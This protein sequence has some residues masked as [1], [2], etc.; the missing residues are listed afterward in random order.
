MDALISLKGIGIP[1]GST[2]LQFAFPDRY[3]ILDWRALEALGQ[4]KR[5][6]Y[7]ISFWVTYVDACRKIAQEAGVS[8]RTLDKALWQW[9]RERSMPSL[10]IFPDDPAAHNEP[11]LVADAMRL[12]E[13]RLAEIS[14]EEEHLERALGELGGES[15]TTAEPTDGFI[16]A[17]VVRHDGLNLPPSSLPPRRHRHQYGDGP[18]ANLRMPP[19]PN[20]AGI[21]LWEQDGEVVYVGQTRQPLRARLGPQGYA[22]ITDYNTY[23]QSSGKG[24]GQQTN[25]RINA[26]AN[27]A[28]R[29]GHTLAIWHRTMSAEDARRE[30]ARWMERFGRPTWNLRL[31]R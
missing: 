25:C 1:M 9:S 10:S 28:L 5:T 8:V 30:E 17:G 12:I 16:R 3:P 4:P 29:D 11:D 23:A 22:R 19:L 15:S 20:E 2:L 26:L 27:Q 24:G 7:P 14:S 31:E 18:F 6:Q 13:D 21:Y